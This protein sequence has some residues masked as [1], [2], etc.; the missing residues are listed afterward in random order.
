MKKTEKKYDK[1][2]KKGIFRFE[3][4]IF[5]VLLIIV[6]TFLT[7]IKPPVKFSENENRTLSGRPEFS[8]DS[9]V[10]GDFFSSLGT[11]F[12]DQFAGRDMWMRMSAE[13]KKLEGK[14]DIGGCYIGKDGYLF[15]EPEKPDKEA[16]ENTVKAINRFAEKNKKLHIYALFVP[17]A[18]SILTEKLPL[19]A[20]VGNQIKDLETM[21]K[22]LKNVKVLDPVKT[23]KDNKDKYIYYR[24]DHHWTSCGAYQVFKATAPE[25]GIDNPYKY[26]ETKVTESFYGTLSSKTGIFRNPDSVSLYKPE[27]CK[28]NYVVN[29]MNDEDLRTTCFKEEELKKKD[30]YLVFFG[31]NY[32]V[33]DI[34]TTS[35]SNRSLLV[36][37]DSYANSY[38]QFLYP[39][40]R[41]IIVIDPRYYYDNVETVIKTYG[42][43]DVLFIYSGNTIIKDTNL[44]DALG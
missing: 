29:Y 26:K 11:Y 38:I 14:K 22:G 33:I 13:G 9:L 20:P 28:V 32:P 25:M 8:F 1:Q 43:T 34:K 39:Y 17:G 18:P 4:I 16:C 31:G 23:L 7:V 6:C 40:Y 5:T 36:L 30:K 12:T 27:D 21:E 42:I 44:A 37:K 41:R 19:K 15:E 35:D 10:S 2:L 3:I 24:T